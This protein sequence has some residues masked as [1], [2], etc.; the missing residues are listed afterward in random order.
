MGGSS[1]GIVYAH[2]ITTD[3]INIEDENNEPTSQYT[4]P[5]NILDDSTTIPKPDSLILNSDGRFFRVI[6]IDLNK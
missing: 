2:G 5:I 4:L 6:S 3:I 1:T